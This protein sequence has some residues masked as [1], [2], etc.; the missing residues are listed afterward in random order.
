MM[1]FHR[2][3]FMAHPNKSIRYYRIQI[4]ETNHEQNESTMRRGVR[5]SIAGKTV[6]ERGLWDSSI[7]A[8]V[9]GFLRVEK[10]M[11]DRSGMRK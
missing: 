4:D 9:D 1:T 10:E 2:L 3:C 7:L 11:Q 5:E 6:N 8:L